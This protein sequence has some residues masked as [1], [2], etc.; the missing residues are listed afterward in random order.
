LALGLVVRPPFVFFGLGA[1]SGPGVGAGVVAVDLVLSLILMGLPPGVEA[2]VPPG[3]LR[4]G[5]GV[6]AVKEGP[7]VV[8]AENPPVPVLSFSFEVESL[9][10][11]ILGFPGAS[12]LQYRRTTLCMVV[13]Y[14]GKQRGR[15]ADVLIKFGR[16]HKSGVT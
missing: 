11:G 12:I 9:S 10:F 14:L 6:P 5:P 1:S 8:A 15:K 16:R 3:V 7:G 13:V 2:V 4:T